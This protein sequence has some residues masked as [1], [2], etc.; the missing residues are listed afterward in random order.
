MTT[1]ETIKQAGSDEKLLASTVSNLEAW[2][3]GGFL[4]AWA[5]QSIEALVAAS[6]WD[7]LNDRFYKTIAFGT[8]GMRD[9]TIGG[10]VTDAEKGNSTGP[11]PE[12][13]AV[14]AT[15]LND[16]N[17]IRA[18]MGLFEYCR[19]FLIKELGYAE[20]PRLV[21]A[22][23]VRHFSRHFCE[24]AASVWTRL[25][26]FAMI[27]DGPR[28]TPQLSFTVRHVGATAGV[29]ITAS[30]NPPQYNGF[31]AYFS[32]G[33]QVT[34][35]H[36]NGIIARVNAVDNSTLAAYL[37][38][39]LSKVITLPASVDAD[40]IEAVGE[41]VLA[42][43]A[44]ENKIKTV[45]TPIHGTGS[46]ASVPILKNYGVDLV[47]VDEQEVQDGA[48]PTVKSPNPEES[49]ALDMGI[50]KAKETGAEL[51]IATDPDADRMGVAVRDTDGEMKLLTGNQIGSMLLA[52]RI[53]RFRELGVLPEGGTKSAALLKT[54]VTTPLQDRIAE[55]NGLKIINTL[56]GFK[57][58][59]KKL[60]EYEDKLLDT[61]IEE[62]GISLDY[63][64]TDLVKRCELLL[65]YS[66]FYICGGEESYGYLASDRV[67]DKDANA[68]VLMFVEM[69]SYLKG[70]GKSVLQFLD[71]IYIRY[72]FHLESLVNIYYEG[73]AGSQKIANILRSYREDKPTQIGE[74]KVTQFLD[75]G[76]QD[77]KD[78]DG[79]EIPKQD[80]YFLTLDNGYQY[81][82][83]G[84][85]TEPK[86][87][88][89]LFAAEKV[90]KPSALA[91]VK[92]KT[93][94]TLDALAASIKADAERRAE[95]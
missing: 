53:E 64:S 10:I 85:G 30:H 43:D 55:A 69:A 89:Y 93:R 92:A 31:K 14:G 33:A 91:D 25:G 88:F 23:D 26:G 79:V 80:L 59:G 7:E 82:V 40:Y 70:E 58:I 47:L 78:A 15:M 8:G 12:H 84:S 48:F 66:T 11:V 6:A 57:W 17:I 2:L 28:S 44:F 76:V 61:L 36:D 42:Q 29:V 50:R 24:L 18:T 81:A 20:Q 94:V 68:A 45:F 32:D 21:I 38:K 51:V 83:R 16:F 73:A 46:V 71:E 77:L 9:R 19:E 56:T 87:K 3:S 90:S 65:K 41:N 35:P 60:A 54:F 95:G 27:F 62:E 4:P 52:Y 34:P 67:R 13:A 39:D 37:E 63:D 1:L 75:F 22:H 74:N 72:G 86:I 5:L 49:A